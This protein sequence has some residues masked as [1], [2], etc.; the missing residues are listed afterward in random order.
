MCVC[1]CVCACVRVGGMVQDIQVIEWARACRMFPTDI[2]SV[3]HI[4]TYTHV[5]TT[6]TGMHTLSFTLATRIYA[7]VQTCLP[8]KHMHTHVHTGTHASTHVHI[9]RVPVGGGDSRACRIVDC[10]SALWTAGHLQVK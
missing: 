4:A 2:P 7:Y 9:H 6:Y 10:G 8:T 1:V 3:I 5:H